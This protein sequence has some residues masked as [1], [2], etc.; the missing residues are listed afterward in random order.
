MDGY[1]HNYKLE[2][3]FTSEDSL[4]LYKHW[5]VDEDGMYPKT[6]PSYYLD[7]HNLFTNNGYKMKSCKESWNHHL[8]G[9]S[10]MTPLM[11]EEF[12]RLYDRFSLI[13]EE[14]KTTKVQNDRN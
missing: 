10:W 9:K 5:Y 13:T 8:N 14:S 6:Y 7:W 12:H 2:S 4:N 1:L 3:I 11:L